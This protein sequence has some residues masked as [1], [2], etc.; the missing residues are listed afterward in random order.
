LSSILFFIIWG[1]CWKAQLHNNERRIE[2]RKVYDKEFREA[3]VR[4]NSSVVGQTQEEELGNTFELKTAADTKVTPKNAL[5]HN[6]CRMLEEG[7]GIT[8]K[9][10]FA[11]NRLL[12]D[13]L[14]LKDM[15]LVIRDDTWHR[16]QRSKTFWYLVPLLSLFYLI[17][18]CQ[19]VFAEQ[20]RAR[21][22]GNLEQ[23][24]LNYGCS[25]PWWIFDDFNHIIS[26]I[27]YIMYGLVFLVLV[28]LKSF[29][30][31]QENRTETDHMGR[32]GLPQ[33]H[34]LFYTMGICMVM[35]GLFS[36]IFHVCPSNISL[37]F[38][39]TM[40][41]IMMILVFIKIYQFR[42]PDIATNSYHSMYAFSA[43]LLM[44]AAS[45]Y[46]VSTP[47]KIIFYF[48]FCVLYFGAVLHIAIDCYYFGALKTSLFRNLP[49]FAKHSIHNF[50]HCL[51]PKR[52]ALS[53]LFVILNLCLMV[54]TVFRSFEKE[55]KSLSTPILIICALNVGTFLCY[56]MV[57]KIIEI[58]KNPEGP[59]G[60]LRWAM[61][62]FTFIFFLLAITLG[63]IAMLFY[64]KRHQS[65]NSTP[66]ESRDKNELCNVLDFFDNH[67]MWHFFSATALFLS[68]IFLLT[69]DDDLLLTE[70]EK[71][72][73]F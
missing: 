71:I 69:I 6:I 63:A 30:L 5:R 15:S 13:K 3:C 8:G 12:T 47:G 48:L 46:V 10:R 34:S 64:T 33:Q 50:K 25:R 40:M 60:R 43:V 23:C 51:Y 20:Q 31:P 26:N 29:F 11:I 21:S 55:A 59:E 70:R 38:D 67:D 45:L 62:F 68:F 44:E 17:P 36:A 32:I 2:K 28:R 1:G 24:F 39:T 16:R 35:Q 27:G 61:R 49:I 56:Y 54:L 18:S 19:M 57:R 65:R 53:V 37:Q 41:Y 58:F 66:P 42:H 72:E 7:D 4:Q 14:M 22:T 73:V 52:F 9:S